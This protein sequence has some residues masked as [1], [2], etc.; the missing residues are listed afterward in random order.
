MKCKCG[1]DKFIV[2]SRE[3]K[4]KLLTCKKCFKRYSNDKS[5]W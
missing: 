3:K 5:K 4:Y 1:N 2:N